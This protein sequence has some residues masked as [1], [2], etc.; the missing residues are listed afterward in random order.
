M[1]YLLVAP[2]PTSRAAKCFYACV[3]EGLG[4]MIIEVFSVEKYVAVERIVSNNHPEVDKV[5]RIIGKACSTV[6]DFDRC[7]MAAKLLECG[8]RNRPIK[9]EKVFQQINIENK[10]REEA[11]DLKLCLIVR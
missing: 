1:Q 9:W 3:F 5:A 10:K 7:E 4:F 11:N 8:R 2:Q 6:Y